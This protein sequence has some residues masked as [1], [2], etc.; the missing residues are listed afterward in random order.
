[1]N[2][3]IDKK[4]LEETIA[5]LQAKLLA[6]R[7]SHGH[8][9]GRLSSSAL[10]TA[11]AAFAL[12]V[13][14][15]NRHRSLV[16]R[17][18]QWLC[19]H[20]NADG[21]WGDTACSP[22]NL[23][24]TMLCYSAMTAADRSDACERCVERTESW[25]QRRVGSLDPLSLA[26]AV[27]S[28][29]GKDRTF[30]VPILTMCALAGRLGDAGR[31]WRL[32]RPLP[33]ELAVLPHRLFKWLRLPVVS[34]ALPALIAIGQVRYKHR[35]PRNP[36]TW[37]T[38][39]LSV[40]KTLRV[41][42][43]LQPDNGGFLE[44][45]PLTSF[46]VMSL[47]AA[48]HCEHPV[49]AKGVE[50]L[51][52]SIREDG[53]WPIDTNLAGWVTT[54]AIAALSA[55]GLERMLSASER[56]GLLDWLLS[57]QHRGIHPYTQA[58][59]GGW[60]WTDLAGAVPDADDTP[61]AL[62]A[63]HELSRTS[64]INPIPS[65]C[66]GMEWLLNLQNADGGIPT[67]C[68]G[69]TK[70]PFDK[71]T[72][73]L[74]AHTV[75]AMGA[76]LPSLPDSLKGRTEKAMLR[77]L[78]YLKGSQRPNGSW[79]PLWFGN[80]AA[81]NQ[82]N[83]VYGT[84]RA[85]RHLASCA[86]AMGQMGPTGLIGPMCERAARWLLSVQNADG[87]WGG[88]ASVASSIEETALAVDALATACSLHTDQSAAMQAAYRGAQWL[89][90]NTNRGTSL[91]ASPIGLY[92]ARLWYFEELYPLVFTLCALSRVARLPIAG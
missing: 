47:A 59:P 86:A 37:A 23:S 34:Y 17:G 87:G 92:F 72:A 11:T 54:L 88:D 51:A 61:G 73:D 55:G 5:R 44:A 3:R 78:Y 66:A 24:T 28:Q 75:A 12:A 81:A 36:L 90:A 38:R 57:C 77:A 22:S 65:A 13:V 2:P 9:E 14:D 39:R 29:Y 8:W 76:W 53:S 83:P 10:S 1:M 31:A 50:F 32:V 60:A 80:Q 74:T 69:W 20:Q 40:A 25:L 52:A 91:P 84:S 6:A 89:I 19:E 45:A 68:R 46:V 33:F 79:T 62:I 63:L 71:S 49:V 26:R 16:E 56:Q 15:R 85:L 64:S 41:L 7:G 18:R 67:F 82:E 30:S 35:A 42:C 43:T 48:G 21:G 70:L 4:A 58:A 27:E